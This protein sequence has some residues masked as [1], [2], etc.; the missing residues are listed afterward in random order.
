MLEQ[1]GFDKGKT[2]YIEQRELLSRKRVVE[3]RF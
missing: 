1:H 3:W 2:A